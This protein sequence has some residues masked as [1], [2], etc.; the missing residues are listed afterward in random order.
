M[1]AGYLDE[2]K[3]EVKRDRFKVYIIHIS[4]ISLNWHG[5][6]CQM[7][8]CLWNNTKN[9]CYVA[10]EL[11]IYTMLCCWIIRYYFIY[12]H[13]HYYHSI[14]IS[15]SI[16]IMISN[17]ICSMLMFTS[18]LFLSLNT[19]RDNSNVWTVHFVSVRFTFLL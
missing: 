1:P 15:N 19:Y 12:N 4:N 9:E 18:L 7:F 17:S 10:L 2:R 6:N 5:V 16:S 8:L 14:N 3:Q 13:F 11:D